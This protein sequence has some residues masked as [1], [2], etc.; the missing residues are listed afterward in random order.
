MNTIAS[1]ARASS[2]ALLACLC[3]LP[4]RASDDAQT[5]VSELVQAREFG[6]ALAACDAITDPLLRAEWRFH[7]LYGGGDLDAA[8]LAALDGLE[9]APAHAGLSQNA[10]VCAL[11]L[12]RPD[13]AERVGDQLV[14]HGS[15]IPAT[16]AGEIERM[17]ELE[18]SAA[19]RTL[20]S[21]AVVLASSM[22]AVAALLALARKIKR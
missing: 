16:L 20:R 13:V 1:F 21:R 3:A 19:R 8:L 6:Q 5:R 12:R 7:V 17:L 11:K 2:V 10:L 18:R 15:A 9:H 4:A 22:L 14:A